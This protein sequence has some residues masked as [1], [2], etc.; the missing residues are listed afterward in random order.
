MRTQRREVRD[1][2]G[3]IRL[4]LAVAP[5]EDR[6]T[7]A[8]R[9]L[10]DRIVAEVHEAQMLHDHCATLFR[11]SDVADPARWSRRTVVYRSS[12][13]GWRRYLKDSAP[14]LSTEV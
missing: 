3:E 4:A 14:P 2:L 12:R 5:D 11:A 13:L 10:G 1:R 9:D 8:E 7:G 6:G